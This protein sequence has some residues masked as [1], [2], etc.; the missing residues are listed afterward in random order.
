MRALGNVGTNLA[1][2]GKATAF[3]ANSVITQVV[4]LTY[5]IDGDTVTKFVPFG[6]SVGDYLYEVNMDGR[7]FGGWY[8]DSGYSSAVNSQDKLENDTT[9]YAR[10]SDKLVTER[11]LT[12]W[13]RNLWYVLAPCIAVVVLALLV[14][15]GIAIKKRK[16]A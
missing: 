9:I 10:L 12:W 15:V 3:N 5:N 6:K 1:R 2:M 11:P 8:Y 13:E 7:E 16:S 4:T 14:G